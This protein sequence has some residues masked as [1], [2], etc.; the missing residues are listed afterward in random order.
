M[1]PKL[2]LAMSLTG[3]ANKAGEKLEDTARKLFAL[4]G[5]QGFGDILTDEFSSDSRAQVGGANR[6]T[7]LVVGLVVAGLM[8]AF[9]LPIAIEEITNTSTTNWSDGAASLWSVLPIMIV[10]AIFL[11][12]VGLALQNR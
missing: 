2:M 11:F 10:L 6:A 12:F 5:L 4:M 7:N 9:L 8:A 1:L 3:K